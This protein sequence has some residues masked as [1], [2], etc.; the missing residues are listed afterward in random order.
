[1]F[2][3]NRIRVL[4]SRD[5]R[6]SALITVI[7]I[8]AVV[9][10]V[11]TTMVATV[12]FASGTSAEARGE[13]QAQATAEDAIDSML[14]QMSTYSYGTEGSFPCS[15]GYQEITSAGSAE[16]TV[17]LR[18]RSQGSSA[19][20]CPVPSSLEIVEAEMTAVSTVDVPT[21]NG[22]RT[23]T[24]T[25][26]QRLTVD[27]SP[28]TGSLFDYGVFSNGDLT[29]TN[30]FKVNGGGVHTN[31]SFACSVAGTIVGPV[32][33]VK[34]VSLTNSCQTKD[35]RAGGTFEC[36]SGPT[37]TGDVTAAG[38]GT[39]SITNSCTISGSLTAAG[40]ISVSTTTPRVGGNLI[41]S[42]SSITFGNTGKIVT[43]YGRAGTTIKA[44]DGGSLSSIFTGGSTQG[45]PSA[46]PSVPES[47]TMPAITWADL[48]PT[49]TTVKS[50]KSWL[51]ENAVRNGA[52]DWTDP[53][54]GTTC[55][56]DRANYSLNGDLISPDVATVMDARD[57]AV[58]LQGSGGP[59]T[60]TLKNDLTIVAKSLS[61]NNGVRVSS[62]KAGTDAKLRIIVPLAAGVA[63]CSAAATSSGD[64]AFANS[65]LFDSNVDTMLYTNGTI[66]LTNDTTIDG[67]VY[68]CKT[69]VSVRTTITYKD[70]T[71]PG[72]PS[73]NSGHYTWDEVAR[74]NLYPGS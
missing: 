43:G 52:P 46:A 71:P 5:D 8:T 20:V 50:F 53:Y 47:Q 55:T 56:A 62:V 48:T 60:I 4:R 34:N 74:Y 22:M 39:T 26:K 38:T 40:P 54:K 42:G 15:M 33:A 11:T 27:D 7:A 12:T 57:C 23:A 19:L 45:S 65:V 1:M 2:L 32:T 63:T 24:K 72:M 21:A 30:D 37:V 6:G 17:T 35:I 3:R 16:A 13:V 70:M 29:I 51:Q 9:A 25:V 66:S 14:S 68:G 41:S 61:T 64:I 28:E 73:P 10:I 59:L 49:G 36:S 69:N 18:Y 67:S 44:S 31:G 58:T